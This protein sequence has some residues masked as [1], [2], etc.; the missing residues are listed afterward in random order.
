MYGDGA[1]AYRRYQY[2]YGDDSVGR[3]G[4]ST[5]E[6]AQ[7]IGPSEQV[8]EEE[9]EE[10]QLQDGGDG[11][12]DADGEGQVEEQQ[13]YEL[14]QET[15]FN[16]E[17]GG[18]DDRRPDGGRVSDDEAKNDDVDLRPPPPVAAAAAAAATATAWYAF[19][20]N[21][22]SA[23]ARALAAVLSNGVYTTATSSGPR[24]SGRSG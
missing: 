17:P 14:E 22:F 18:R 6:V 19:L 3:D 9:E 24:K 20:P 12:E 21:A 4:P 15:P 13:R 10:H 5:S 23:V 16:E 7:R 11:H 2:H 1:D 8:E